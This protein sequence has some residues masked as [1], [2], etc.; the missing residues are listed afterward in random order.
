MLVRASM[1]TALTY[2]SK[3]WKDAP[4]RQQNV[5]KNARDLRSV[6]HECFTIAKGRQEGLQLTIKCC[7]FKAH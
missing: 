6:Y 7:S 4:H 3:G 2:A 1:R 5:N